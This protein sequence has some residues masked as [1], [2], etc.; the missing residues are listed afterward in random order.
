MI[1][2]LRSIRDA[3][4]TLRRAP[5]AAIYAAVGG[6]LTVGLVHAALTAY[7]LALLA[8][9]TEPGAAIGGARY[10]AVGVWAAVTVL[11]C[12]AVL[13]CGMTLW[14]GTR[15]A[16]IHAIGSRLR[17][18]RRSLGSALVDIR[19]PLV[20]WGV[21]R[22]LSL[23]Y[24]E[25]YVP[26]I[27]RRSRRAIAGTT[28]RSE[29]RRRTAFLPQ[30]LVLESEIDIDSAIERSR[31]RMEVTETVP[32]VFLPILPFVG[33]LSV[34]A[35]TGFL[36]YGLQ[37]ENDLLTSLGVFSLP[38]VF[39]FGVITA[40]TVDIAVRTRCYVELDDV[41]AEG[42]ADRTG[43]ASP[44]RIDGEPDRMRTDR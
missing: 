32:R 35:F 5:A 33:V 41:V 24:V 20:K 19:R 4:A 37:Y 9:G 14:V 21:L 7:P 11:Y 34:V 1:D 39:A 18:R 3:L 27:G 30:A 25:A 40:A 13:L 29:W 6:I 26:S 16:V 31:N 28:S 44:D 2:T 22:W 8:I 15:A 17:G 36:S 38:G 23:G 42:P 10:R 12:G 43:E